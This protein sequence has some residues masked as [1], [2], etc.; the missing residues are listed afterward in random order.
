VVTCCPIGM[1]NLIKAGLPV[2]DLASLLD[3]N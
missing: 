1:A 3:R 2:E